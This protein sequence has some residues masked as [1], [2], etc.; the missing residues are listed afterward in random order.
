M[1][2]AVTRT[3]GGS[4]AWYGRQSLPVGIPRQSLGT[5]A[6]EGERGRYESERMF[7]C[8]L[9]RCSLLLPLAVSLPNHASG[10]D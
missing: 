7:W 9:F 3:L 1:A 10:N 4:A 5:R 2:E 6:N 8:S